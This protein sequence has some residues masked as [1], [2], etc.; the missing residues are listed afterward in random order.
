MD[1]TAV[2]LSTAVVFG[3]NPFDNSVYQ[4]E[5]YK[6]IYMPVQQIKWA[7]I[8]KSN[9]LTTDLMTNQ[10]ISQSDLLN[11]KLSDKLNK[12]SKTTNGDDFKGDLLDKS[13]KIE[14]LENGRKKI[15]IKF[16]I[17]K[18]KPISIEELEA[19]FNLKKQ[20]I[21][22]VSVIGYAS[23]DG[24]RPTMQ[25]TLAKKRADKIVNILRDME[26]KVEDVISIV[27]HK[28]IE[29]SKCWRADIYVEVEE[30]QGE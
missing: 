24:P 26:V 21:K 15:T 22:E 6:P 3:L 2:I 30:E 18:Y 13:E 29:P 11:L 5:V 7:G 4:R 1:I 14:K 23:P 10:E 12:L 28:G 27:C 19:F 16:P 8:D 17:E 9:K 25:E 20:N